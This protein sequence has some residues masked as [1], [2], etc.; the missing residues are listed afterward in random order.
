MPFRSYNRGVEDIPNSHLIDPYFEDKV[1]ERKPQ[2]K[3]KCG[4]AERGKERYPPKSNPDYIEDDFD[5]PAQ[6]DHLNEG[7]SQFI[8]MLYPNLILCEGKKRFPP[9]YE[10]DIM[11]RMPRYT[12][13]A[14]IEEI[15][16]I[17]DVAEVGDMYPKMAF[18]CRKAKGE[19]VI[20]PENPELTDIIREENHLPLYAKDELIEITPEPARKKLIPLD[21]YVTDD[22][23][24]K[25]V[26]DF[27]GSLYPKLISKPVK[28]ED[29]ND[30][31][32]EYDSE[33]LSEG[34][35]QFIEMLYPNLFT[36]GISKKGGPIKTTP[37]SNII[38][39]MKV[40]Q[41]M[42]APKPNEKEEECLA[43]Q[44][45]D[46]LIAEGVIPAPD[47]KSTPT[48]IEKPVEN[49][50]AITRS[51]IAELCDPSIDRYL[52]FLEERL[53]PQLKKMIIESGDLEELEKR[54]KAGQTGRSEIK[55]EFKPDDNKQDVAK[56]ILSL[57]REITPKG[58]E[59]KPE[60]KRHCKKEGEHYLD[61]DIEDIED[62]LEAGCEAEAK[63]MLKLL[64]KNI[65]PNC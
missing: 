38:R 3:C 59:A 9:R 25:S 58:S 56:C 23:L 26:R 46:K 34:I 43:C 60:P 40:P 14:P 27:T 22:F 21:K 42:S 10:Q 53:Y 13:L 55:I 65:L 4:D 15:A 45:F 24:R 62:A 33:R 18:E 20:Q 44:S 61:V 39:A 29:S 2:K 36:C 31:S 30:D 11:E 57:V 5:V 28:E 1:P 6:S 19:A 12:D 64:R 32:G 8:N 47:I 50:A 48:D 52:T 35:L 49:K 54:V 16:D 17:E 37:P 7:I 41:V 51:D 63:E